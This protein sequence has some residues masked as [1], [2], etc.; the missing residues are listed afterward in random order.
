[1]EHS[2]PEKYPVDFD[3]KENLK[4]ICSRPFPEPTLHKEMFKKEVERLVLLGVLGVAN[5][6]ERRALYFA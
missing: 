3:L 5:D 6:S 2:T 4:P 1:M